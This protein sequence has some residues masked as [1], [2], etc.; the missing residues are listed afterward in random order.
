MSDGSR[1]VS[2]M[3]REANALR[4]V[5]EILKR[6]LELLERDPDLQNATLYKGGEMIVPLTLEDDWSGGV[7]PD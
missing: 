6:Q 2:A 7:G 3:L 4:I 1:D 5:I